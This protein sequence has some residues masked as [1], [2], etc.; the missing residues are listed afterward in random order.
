MARANC[1]HGGGDRRQNRWS[2]PHHSREPTC[3]PAGFSSRSTSRTSPRRRRSTSGLLGA[4]PHKQAR[5]VCQ[6]RHRGPPTEAGAHREPR[7]RWVRLNHLGV[8]APAARGRHRRRWE[9]FHARGLRRHRG[10][11][12]SLCCHAV[13][14]KVFIGRPRRS[15][16]LVGVLR[17]HRRQ[18]R[19][20]GRAVD[21]GVHRRLRGSGHGREPLAA[22]DHRQDSGGR[23]SGTGHRGAVNRSR[24]PRRC[25]R[26]GRVC[27]PPGRR[28]RRG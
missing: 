8:E 11:A 1:V 17:G 15:A 24:S 26:R 10:R 27:S 7:L 6:L 5:R 2:D 4:P 25:H 14:D 23:P 12:G 28:E 21:V 20:P 22:S 3:R 9:R 18:S 19:Q 16:G 13:Q